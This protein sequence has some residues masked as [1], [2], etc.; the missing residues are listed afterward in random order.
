MTKNR[1]HCSILAVWWLLA[2]PNK[3][4]LNLRRSQQFFFKK[5]LNQGKG[6]IVKQNRAALCCLK[7]EIFQVS[8][9]GCAIKGADNLIIRQYKVFWFI[10]PFRGKATMDR[11]IQPID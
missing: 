9:T 3:G 4:L 6:V 11:H 8:A 7:H 1:K 5:T 2:R 10:A